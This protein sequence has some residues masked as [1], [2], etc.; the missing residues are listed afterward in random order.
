MISE[1]RQASKPRTIKVA[2][3][4]QSYKGNRDEMIH[5]SAAQIAKAA[6]LGAELVALQE[7]HTREYF[8]QSEDPSLFDYAY[9]FEADVAFFAN[10]A[11]KHNIVLVSSLFER[12][13]AGLYHNTA[14]VFEKEDRKSVV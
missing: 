13:S 10:L 3:I 11:K 8:C 5:S 12:R 9:D 4:Q 1:S 6:D 2:L 7:L 14:V